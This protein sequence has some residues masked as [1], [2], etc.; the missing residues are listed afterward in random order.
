MPQV[1]KVWYNTTFCSLFWAT[2][3]A[4]KATLQSVR[5]SQRGYF[6]LNICSSSK[7][8]YSAKLENTFE[9]LANFQIHQIYILLKHFPSPTGESASVQGHACKKKSALNLLFQVSQCHWGLLVMYFMRWYVCNSCLVANVSA[10]SFFQVFSSVFIILCHGFVNDV[11][12]TQRNS[13][14]HRSSF[15]PLG[16]DI[17]DFLIDGNPSRANNLLC[18]CPFA[19]SLGPHGNDSLSSKVAQRHCL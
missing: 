8:K 3:S 15:F 16:N 7:N 19:I 13:L 12:M 1:A 2:F 6:Y 10:S 17:P 14:C 9:Y 4:H 18:Q 5:T 11:I